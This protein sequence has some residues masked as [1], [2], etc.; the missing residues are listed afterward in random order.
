MFQ[1]RT[2]ESHN[3]HCEMV[4]KDPSLF[5]AY[6]I[7]R[8]SVLNQSRYFH[9]V[10]GL[11]LDIMHDQLEEVLPLETK[12]LLRKVIQVDR[13]ITLETGLPHSTMVQLIKKI[14]QVLS[15]SR[16]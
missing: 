5:P 14:N 11:D 13:V 12:M 16:F 4:T 8:A 9:V 6:E 2:R 15:S 10:D 1:L 3:R 7:K